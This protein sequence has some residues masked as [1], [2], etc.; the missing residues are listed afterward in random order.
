MTK[1]RKSVPKGV[2]ARP[3]DRNLLAQCQWRDKIETYYGG[4]DSFLEKS[5]GICLV[6]GE[7]VVSEAYVTSYGRGIAEIGVITQEEHRRK[8]YATIVCAHLIEACRQRGYGVYWS[9]D[10]QN[11]A[12]VRTAQKLGFQSEGRYWMVGYHW[13]EWWEKWS[14]NQQ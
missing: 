1:L 8:G 5:V 6:E 9:C 12:S 11:M 3:M 7:E 2:A 10:V 14:K 13:W 4:L